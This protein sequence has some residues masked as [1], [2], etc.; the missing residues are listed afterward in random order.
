MS[1]TNSTSQTRSL[2][3]AGLP[4]TAALIP[5]WGDDQSPQLLAQAGE[6]TCGSD[7]SCDIVIAMTGVAP[8]HGSL[9]NHNGVVTVVPVPGFPVWLNDAAIDG[10]QRLQHGDSLAVGPATFRV[11]IQAIVP[12][13]AAAP[14]PV[15]SDGLLEKIRRLEERVA[16]AESG[17]S[18]AAPSALFETR[19]AEQSIRR[20]VVPRRE[21]ELQEREQELNRRSEMLQQQLAMFKD[22]KQRQE[23][24]AATEAEAVAAQRAEI[25]AEQAQLL[26]ELQAETDRQ[27]ALLQEQAQDLESREAALRE[28]GRELEDE[29]DR[30]Q[31]QQ[32][33]VLA[34][35]EQRSQA[36]QKERDELASSRAQVNLELE[37]LNQSLAEIAQ[38]RDDAAATFER[39][40]VREQELAGFQEE[41][42]HQH[43]QLAAREAALQEREQSFETSRHTLEDDARE[44]AETRATDRAEL[45]SQRQALAEQAR[46]LAA[47]DEQLQARAR[48]LDETA[49]QLQQQTERLNQELAELDAA[50]GEAAVLE[51]N[52]RALAAED[53]RLKETVAQLEQRESALEDRARELADTRD[54]QL[55]SLQQQLQSAQAAVALQQEAFEESQLALESR[56][57]QLAQL[58]QQLQQQDSDADAAA[59]A[60][61]EQQQLLAEQKAAL[62]QERDEL[63]TA[64]QELSSDRAV[65]ADL[66][67][68]LE[69][70]RSQLET[71]E[72]IFAE[73]QHEEA[74][75]G[76]DEFLAQQEDLAVRDRQLKAWSTELDERQQWVADQ[77]AEAK[78]LLDSTQQQVAAAD[79]AQALAGVQTQLTD[80]ISERDALQVERDHLTTALNELKTAF[81]VA[82]DELA[83]H[84]AAPA[85]DPAALVDAQQE[86]EAQSADLQ[87]AQAALAEAERQN[88]QLREQLVK[89]AERVEQEQASTAT[90][91]AAAEEEA[92]LHEVEALRSELAAV[93]PGGG[94]SEFAE[95]VAEYERTILEL[96]DQLQASTESSATDL[97][98]VSELKTQLEDQQRVIDELNAR[99]ETPEVAQDGEEIARQ[100][101]ELDD[102]INVLD[103]REASIR[104]RQRMI[105]Q[106]EAELEGQRR[107][108]LEARQKLELAR[109]EIHLAMQTP[110]DSPAEPADVAEPSLGASLL[111]QLEA[112]APAAEPDSTEEQVEAA[113]A[114]R[115]EIAELFGL[116][117]SR[118]AAEPAV[119]D[120]PVATAVE[121]SL[122]AVDEYSQEEAAEVSMNFDQSVLLSPEPEPE[123]PVEAAADEEDGDDFVASY[124]EQLLA[125]NRASAG[126]SLPEELKEPEKKSD[127][128]PEKPAPKPGQTSFIESYMAGEYDSAPPASVSATTDPAQPA[129]PRA[130]IDLN[131]LRNDMNSCR[132]LSTKSVESALASH[133]KKQ[134]QGGLT[135]RMAILM[136]LAATSAVVLIAAFLNVISFGLL[137]WLPLIA[138]VGSGVELFLKKASIQKKVEHT[139]AVME[140]RATSDVAEAS[141]VDRPAAEPAVAAEATTADAT[142]AGTMDDTE[143][144]TSTDGFVLMEEGGQAAPAAD[145]TPEEDEYFEL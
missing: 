109:A 113:P 62:Q 29:R 50:A 76:H 32:V 107:E 64:A 97:P 85:A 134:E 38:Q 114:V 136:G 70:G 131:A 4:T 69:Q 33:D 142:V 106:G 46:Q 31:Q 74:T 14:S 9:Y 132:E 39:A 110:Q 83:A 67:E 84:A 48:Q 6:Y 60:Q 124:M 8:R 22:R 35:D 47:T 65:L 66:R 45:E 78:E 11:E 144:I 92:L 37:Q 143:V 130:R 41:L 103:E 27:Q 91:D 141:G 58:Q 118:V 128:E 72:Q 98:V 100:H 51:E 3:A 36:M 13:V 120:E 40:R 49:E 105:E 5:V 30:L 86:I 82:R 125:R 121:S 23:H 137:V 59:R 53:A 116:T 108:M 139:T 96:R 10:P 55:Q 111:E 73:R 21:R 145:Q 95:Q 138:T 126:G 71:A 88:D 102:R 75:T 20:P 54:V 68:Q 135:T 81:E 43:T 93:S 52:R 90:S 2:P 34:H 12:P 18:L 122:P 15:V 127:P 28:R 129:A 19:L 25:Q 77:V 7:P 56:D 89:L 99:L 123:A 26:T 101:R 79:E 115:S 17:T 57:Q 112:R 63:E 117:E 24:R 104:E 140:G 61:H 44:I 80:V 1:F 16:E 42:Q 119:T 133:A 87:E 94:S